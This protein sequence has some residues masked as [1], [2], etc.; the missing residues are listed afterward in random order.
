[1]YRL[2]RDDCYQVDAA[3]NGIVMLRFSVSDTVITLTL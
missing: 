1:M 2:G 3:C